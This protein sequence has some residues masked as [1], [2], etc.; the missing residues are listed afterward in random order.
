MI[1]KD[2]A[3]GANLQTLV[4]VIENLREF[5][6]D[7]EIRRALELILKGNDYE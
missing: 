3:L 4:M 5:L 1:D 2:I 6:S 7:D